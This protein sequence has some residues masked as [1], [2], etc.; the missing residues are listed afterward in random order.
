MIIDYMDSDEKNDNF[1]GCHSHFFGPFKYA[2]HC[3][4]K[5]NVL[6][7]MNVKFCFNQNYL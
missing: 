7:G 4:T 5:K 1:C 3:A 6:F 2:T